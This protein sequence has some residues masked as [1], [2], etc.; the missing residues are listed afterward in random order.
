MKILSPRSRPVPDFEENEQVLTDQSPA[1]EEGKFGGKARKWII[2]GLVCVL[3]LVGLRQLAGIHPGMPGYHRWVYTPEKYQKVLIDVKNERSALASAYNSAAVEGRQEV[4]ESARK[5][6]Q[7]Q[8]ES[9]L[10][11]FWYGTRWAYHGT[12]QVP[13]QGKIACG[14]FVTTVLRDMGCE[15]DRSGLAQAPSETMIKALTDESHIQRY[16]G[17]ALPDFVKKVK[18][19]GD[20][21]YIVGLDTHTGFITCNNGKVHFV[22][23]GGH[24]VIREPALKSRTLKKSQYR[25]TGKLSHDDTFIKDWLG[26][27]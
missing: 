24:S 12:T 6:F 22:H 9:E 23:S 13:G 20:G 27:G 4:L 7:E 5:A 2:L 18:A 8:V 3:G 16:S 10:F 1:G 14:Y 19:Q 21:L 11:P 15:I 26:V 25:V 17:M